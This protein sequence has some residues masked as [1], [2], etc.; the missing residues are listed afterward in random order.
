MSTLKEQYHFLEHA[1][2]EVMNGS[3]K[4]N[5][6]YCS[7]QNALNHFPTDESRPSGIGGKKDKNEFFRKVQE[8][9]TRKDLMEYDFAAYSRYRRALDDWEALN[10]P[11]PREE[12]VKCYLLFGEPGTG[13]T[14][15]AFAQHPGEVYRI[16][17]GEKLWLTP[18]A[19]GKKYFL[20]DDFIGKNVMKLDHLLQI[21]D[22]Y[23]IELE[24][25]GAHVWFQPAEIYF[26]TNVP[27]QQWYNFSDRPHGLR[28]LL[29][30]FHTAYRFDK[31]EDEFPAPY[32]IDI[33]NPRHFEDDY[34]KGEPEP[35]PIPMVR[36]DVRANAFI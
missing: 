10:P 17:P 32:E 11:P 8:G 29:R 7:K 33:A 12:K 35:D 28:A 18:W 27:P 1:H 34:V 6:T 16:P 36:W 31:N 14:E 20:F 13:K 5:E 26:S 3:W 15:T 21:M 22:N 25:K 30:R 2:L 24:R 19:Q 23:P 4:E 9:Y